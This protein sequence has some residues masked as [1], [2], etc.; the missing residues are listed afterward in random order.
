MVTVY[1][2][3][4]CMQCNFTKKYLDDKLLIDIH[5]STFK[6]E[7]DIEDNY[8]IVCATYKDGEIYLD[9]VLGED[10]LK[11]I[12]PMFVKEFQ[13]I[14]ILSQCVGYIL[15]FYIGD[16]LNNGNYNK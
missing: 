4:N 5:S 14:N 9:E 13:L 6:D 3:P 15:A 8:K 10:K 11:S 1:T 2:K 7:T 16:I 12:L